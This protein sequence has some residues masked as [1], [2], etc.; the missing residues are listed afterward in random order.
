MRLK[1]PGIGKDESC[2]VIFG[3]FDMKLK[4]MNPAFHHRLAS[5]DDRE[6][7]ELVTSPAEGC[8]P[9]PEGVAYLLY[10]RYAPLLKSLY[11]KVYG[12]CADCYSDCLADLFEYLRRGEP[13]WHKLRDFGWRTTFG[14]WLRTIAYRRFVEEK[15]AL[16]SVTGCSVPLDE[17]AIRS[18][19]PQSDDRAEIPHS[20]KNDL[21]VLLVEGIAQ[22]KDADRRFVLLRQLDGYDSRGIAEMLGRRWEKYGIVK[23]GYVK[24]ENSAVRVRHVV[25]PDEK[26]VNSLLQ[27]AREELRR[28]VGELIKNT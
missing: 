8:A 21:R 10:E 12:A 16:R 17:D 18:K 22:L 23:Y 1:R 3:L 24:T 6:L 25:V 7:I 28:I 2:K 9:D 15:T 13:A 14:G 11:Y 4:E 20:G 27:H 19:V 26:Y 5:M